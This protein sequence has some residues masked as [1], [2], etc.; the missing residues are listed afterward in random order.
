MSDPDATESEDISSR[1]AFV[2][3]ASALPMPSSLSLLW[4]RSFALS[5]HN[6]AGQRSTNTWH[7]S[8]IWHTKTWLIIQS[9]LG[10]VSA[11]EISQRQ[12]TCQLPQKPSWGSLKNA[13]VVSSRKRSLCLEFVIGCGSLGWSSVY[14]SCKTKTEACCPRKPTNF[15][16]WSLSE[17]FISNMR[18]FVEQ[19]FLHN[20]YH[21]KWWHIINVLYY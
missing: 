5:V 16:A 20:L 18:A 3:S 17:D 1:R 9:H 10:G 7:T 14:Q 21:F 4:E 13:C 2:S 11:G 8:P 12:A 19:V 6:E 15:P